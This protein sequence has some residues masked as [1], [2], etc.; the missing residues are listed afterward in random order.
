M[1]RTGINLTSPQDE[2]SHME[3][4]EKE[5]VEAVK[6]LEEVLFSKDKDGSGGSGGSF[7]GGS[8]GGGRGV[9]C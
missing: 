4:K 5:L 1:T 3:R 9:F 7:G 2:I 8:L 6:K